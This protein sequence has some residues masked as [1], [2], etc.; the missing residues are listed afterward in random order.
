MKIRKKQIIGNFER[1]FTNSSFQIEGEFGESEEVSVM[2][3]T[4]YTKL[5]VFKS[6]FFLP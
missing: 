6:Q 5:N 4:L 3:K 1:K 2:Y